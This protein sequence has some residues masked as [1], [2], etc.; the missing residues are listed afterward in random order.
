MSNRRPN[1]LLLSAGRRVSLAR[2]FRRIAGRHNARFICADLRPDLSAACQD[3][4][5]SIALPPVDSDLYAEVLEKV[6]QSYEIGLV[7]PTIDTELAVLASLRDAFGAAG[8]SIAVSSPDLI[9]IAGDKRK[10]AE[11]FAELGVRSPTIYSNEAPRYPAIAKPFNGSLSRDVH[12]ITTEKDYTNRISSIPNLMLAEYIDPVEHDEFTCDAYYDREEKLR[13][14]VPR[15]RLEVRGGEV[16]KA[17]T[18]YNN[19]VDM[20]HAKLSTLP[21]A[22]GCL[23]FQFFR[24]RTAGRLYLI[25]LNARFGGGFPLALAAG[26]SYPEWLYSEWVL[27]EKIPERLKWETGLTMLRYD[28]EI[29]IPGSEANG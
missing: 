21:G 24:N 28:G 5:D 14:V 20:F 19:I 10:T 12:V 27:G 2:A 23:T 26:A 7:V 13:C 25:E 18:V 6:C 15:L 17:R 29:L 3:N 8:T 22:R 4:S 1:I 11:Y 16:S 9:K